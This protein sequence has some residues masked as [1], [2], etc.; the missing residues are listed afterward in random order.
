[1]KILALFIVL[2]CAT[3]AFSGEAEKVFEQVRASVVT[4]TSLD[5][6]NQVDGEGSGVVTGSG[7]VV[8]NCHV[9]QDAVFIRVRAGGKEFPATVVSGNLQRD[10]CRLE[11]KE[12]AVPAVNFRVSTDVNA[13]ESVHAVGNPLGF[14]LAVGSGLVSAIKRT[15]NDVQIYTSAPTSPGSSGGG[16]FDS[17]GR[18]IGITTARYLGAQNFNMALPTEWVTEL[19]KNG[20]PWST[21]LK[22]KPDPDW[23]GRAESLRETGKW[24]KLEEWARSWREFWPSSV[25]AETFLGLALSNQN[26][27]QDARTVLTAALKKD[28]H[29]AMAYGYRAGVRRIQGDREG[30]SED[31]RRAQTLQPSSGYFFR[32]SATWF[33]EDGDSEGALAAI[34]AAI[35]REPWDWQAWEFLGKLRHGQ[36][37]YQEAEKAYRTVLR[38]KPD[39]ST[40]AINLAS[41]LA[42]LGKSDDARQTL[43]KGTPTDTT[44]AAGTWASIGAAEGKKQ[45]YEESEKAYR[46][47]IELNPDLAEAWMGLGTTLRYIGRAKDAED[48]LRKALNLKPVLGGA[49]YNLGAILAERGDKEGAKDAYEKAT[50]AD[51]SFVPAWIF[52]GALHFEQRNMAAAVTAYTEATKLDPANGETWAYLGVA[53]VRSGQGEKGI[54][55]LNKAESLNPKNEV[56]LQGLAL[57]YGGLHGD[58][59]RALGYL[60]RG[61]AINS[62]APAFWSSKGYALLKLKRYPEAVQALETAI[63]LQPDFANAWINLGEAQLRQNQVG[64]AIGTLEKALQLSPTAVDARFYVAQCYAGTRQFEKAQSHMDLL[65]QQSPK[66]PAAWSMQAAIF[67]E[68]N[69]RLEALSAYTNLKSLSPEMAKDLRQRYRYRGLQYELPE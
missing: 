24:A 48:A 60:E 33:K 59:E 2:C 47:A 43:A 32:V 5:E 13:G 17:Q 66:V 7:Q 12:L 21:Q 42:F 34:E 20:A 15:G 52:L 28:P 53:L 67:L 31:I 69:K 1:M 8:T 22:V 6:Q 9:V 27:N 44:H 30:A 41:I 57:Y 4:I 40:A 62:A 25:M 39:D 3:P 36:Q 45:H 61:L 56:A 64:K 49:W 37:Q 58:Q 11:V 29:Y 55:A 26:K 63:R 23:F 14:G 50:G 54:E 35:R 16:L 65:I 19:L 18:L 46:K 10:L 68:Q 38:L 51:P